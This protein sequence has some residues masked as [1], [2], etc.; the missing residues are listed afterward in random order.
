[1][2]N[3][4]L[5]KLQDEEW[6][7]ITWADKHYEVSNYGRVKSFVYDKTEGRMVRPGNIRGF[8]S[9][10]F[11]TNGKTKSHLVH[12]ITAELFVPKDHDGQDTVIHL[13]W[14]KQNNH[15]TNLQWVTKEEA[16]KRMFQRIQENRRKSGKKVVTSS[17]LKPEDVKLLKS[18]L[19][20]GVK[21]NIIARLFSISEMQVTRIKRGENWG[22]I[23]PDEETESVE[24]K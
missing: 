9:V 17:K 5:R 24:K 22:E 1:M 23:V 11:R 12:K 16:Y 3:R 2:E 4:R 15:Y 10:S 18:M 14:N 13:D 8:L 19:K 20:R 21:Q 6:R 7:Q